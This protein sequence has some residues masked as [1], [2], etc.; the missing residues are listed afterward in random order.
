MILLC[1]FPPSWQLHIQ[2][3]LFGHILKEGIVNILDNLSLASPT[4]SP[5][6]SFYNQRRR[7]LLYMEAVFIFNV[8]SVA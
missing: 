5:N 2:N 3:P 8:Q 4:L 7:P 1:G 6:R